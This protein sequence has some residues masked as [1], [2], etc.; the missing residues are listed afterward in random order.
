MPRPGGRPAG[1]FKNPPM[2]GADPLMGGLGASPAQ[3]IRVVV[4][5]GLLPVE[6][7]EQCFTP[8]AGFVLVLGSASRG[9]VFL[10][11]EALK[12]C[13]LVVD[14]SVLR[15]IA[16]EE[17]KRITDYG[18][19]IQVLVRVAEFRADLLEDL[20]RLGCAGCL[21]ADSTAAQLK[22]AVQSVASG[23]LWASRKQL[24]AM[25]RESLSESG[26]PRLTAREQEILNLMGRGLSN[27]EIAEELCI[28]RETV[29]WHQRGLYAKIGVHDRSR[30]VSL[31]TQPEASKPAGSEGLQVRSRP[32]VA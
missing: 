24:S 2:K 14:E 11:C 9:G 31:T 21:T 6:D 32:A 26:Q 17:F 30:A 15:A 7:L 13:V 22:R 10:C 18:R 27:R 3:P 5:A 29:R 12:P 4:S 16:P 23:E 8:E 25:L 20:L 1:R 28:S 19:S